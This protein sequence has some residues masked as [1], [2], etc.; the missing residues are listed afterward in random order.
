MKKTLLI[1]AAA[2]AAGVITSQAQGP[3]Y[4]QNIVGYANLTCPTG[5]QNYSFTCQFAVGASNGVN[6]IF[7]SSLPSGTKILTWNGVNTFNTTVFDTSDPNED[8][9]GPWFNGS[10][11]PLASLPRLLPGQGFFLVPS[12]PVTNTFAGAIAINVGSSNAMNFP[13]PFNNYF[14]GS[15]VPYAG[16]ATNGTSLGGGVNLNSLTS[17]TK[18]LTWNGVNTYNTS[19]FDTSDPNE[20]GSGPWFNGSFVPTAPP[21]IAVGQG[22]FIVTPGTGFTWTNGLPAN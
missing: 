11:V 13:T 5:F 4:S 10:F 20:D 7:G 9:S 1:A 6:E 15:V 19:V 16:S 22:F 21:T 18:I 12:A 8:G 17:G 3:V 14:V 2:L